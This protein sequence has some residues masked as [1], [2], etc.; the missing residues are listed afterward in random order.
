VNALR[1]YEAMHGAIVRQVHGTSTHVCLLSDARVGDRIRL[2]HHPSPSATGGCPS[3]LRKQTIAV[4][5]V[6]ERLDEHYAVVTFPA[7][8]RTA[9]GHRLEPFP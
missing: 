4:G 7:G 8:T 6:T 3:A 2:I 5:C 9:E 1:L